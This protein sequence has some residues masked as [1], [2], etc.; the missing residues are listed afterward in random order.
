MP[1]V[2]SVCHVRLSVPSLSASQCVMSC[3]LFS[4]WYALSCPS[5]FVTSWAYH[6]LCIVSG[7][8]PDGRGRVM[9]RGSLPI[10]RVGSWPR[11]VGVGGLV[12]GFF[13]VV[14]FAP[15]RF[16]AGRVVALGGLFRCV[17]ILCVVVCCATKKSRSVCLSVGLSC[18]S[19]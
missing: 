16:F 4:R 13:I 15:L 1:A 19:P 8:A 12:G 6:P 9:D 10:R 2:L 14:V 11:R 18:M 7:C 17:A 5:V 3:P